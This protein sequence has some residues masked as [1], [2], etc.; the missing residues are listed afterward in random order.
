M[1][2]ISVGLECIKVDG[3]Y[4]ELLWAM[5]DDDRE[6][7]ISFCLGVA[8]H[9]IID[10]EDPEF[11]LSVANDTKLLPTI[12]SYLS[13][14]YP[15][16]SF[17]AGSLIALVSGLAPS[18]YYGHPIY[19]WPVQRMVE[20]GVLAVMAPYVHRGT[21]VSDTAVKALN[22]IMHHS[23][24]ARDTVL[25]NHTLLDEL[26]AYA[27]HAET[28]T[29]VD[30]A[31]DTLHRLTL[32]LPMPLFS[33]IKEVLPIA[34]EYI[35][36]R[37]EEW[38]LE[39][40]IACIHIYT[41]I[42]RSA[43][44]PTE[45]LMDV[46]GEDLIPRL[47]ELSL[48]A[49]PIVW[50]SAVDI[51]H[52]ISQDISPSLL[53]HGVMQYLQ[54][55]MLRFEA[56]GEDEEMRWLVC[57]MANAAAFGETPESETNVEMAVSSGYVDSAVRQLSIC[58]NP[59][60]RSECYGHSS[61]LLN[62]LSTWNPLALGQL[63]EDKNFKA[64]VQAFETLEETAPESPDSASYLADTVWFLQYVLYEVS[65]YH[66]DHSHGQDHHMYWV[67]EFQA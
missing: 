33:D 38:D 65:S 27:R 67:Q 51:L 15:A 40:L 2:S 49:E 29:E 34:A 25:Q 55:L 60:R 53:G 59:S 8:R 42:G 54:T 43:D 24:L 58:G 62:L 18:G 1:T 3:M 19:S 45:A 37:Q 31:I 52:T 61:F 12:I 16:E 47:M 64:M 20:E 17:E 21:L 28:D 9:L 36:T 46:V 11:A 44:D 41:I 66:H 23:V 57:K 14:G 50:R 63:E 48:H 4:H 35:K 6:T 5:D 32:G 13:E 10:E 26:L 56:E 7:V 39:R 30:N 22:N